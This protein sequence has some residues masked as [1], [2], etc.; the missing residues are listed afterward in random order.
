M[1]GFD[2]RK[3]QINLS[4]KALEEYQE[5]Q[6]VSAFMSAQGDANVTFGDLFAKEFSSPK[7]SEKQED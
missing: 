7:E 4:K 2:K 5:K 3:R 1:I 6:Q